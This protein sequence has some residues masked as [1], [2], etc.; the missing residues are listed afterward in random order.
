MCELEYIFFIFVGLFFFSI[1]YLILSPN[2][3]KNLLKLLFLIEL[4]S[5]NFCIIILFTDYFYGW[6]NINNITTTG[7][8]LVL[9]ILTI[10]AL[11]AS[12]GLALIYTY[13]K[14]WRNTN[15]INLNKFKN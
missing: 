14:F 8:I 15:I 7:Q 1:F 11:E 4:I 9:F 6:N 10:S 5:L 12:I 3:N 13:F 2:L